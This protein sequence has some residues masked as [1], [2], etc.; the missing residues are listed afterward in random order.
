MTEDFMYLCDDMVKLYYRD[1]SSISTKLGFSR[2][3]RFRFLVRRYNIITKDNKNYSFEIKW[4]D[5]VDANIKRILNLKNS[6]IKW[7]K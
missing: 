4:S 5:S 7:N 3:G 1:I 2:S 6:N